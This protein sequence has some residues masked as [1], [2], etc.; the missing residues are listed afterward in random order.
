MT[1]LMAVG[2]IAISLGIGLI[3]IL[4]NWGGEVQAPGTVVEEGQVPGTI[5]YAE[6]D[7]DQ[8]IV[9]IEA[10]G[11]DQQDLVTRPA[12]RDDASGFA[13]SPDGQWIA[14]FD[15]NEEDESS[16]A[17]IVLTSAD[18]SESE[19]INMPPVLGTMHL[20]VGLGWSHDGS[21]LA[22]VHE[23]EATGQARIGIV[24]RESGELQVI[25]PD[26]T[27]QAVND[28]HPVWAPTQLALAF[29]R[30]EASGQ[31]SI[32]VLHQD[33]DEP[34]V[35]IQDDPRATQPGW[36]P[37]GDMIAYVGSGGESERHNVHLADLEADQIQNLSNHE[38]IDYLPTWSSRDQIAFMSDYGDTNYDIFVV[39]PAGNEL[40]NLTED[41]AWSA[42]HPDWSDD[43]RYLTFTSENPEQNRWRINVFDINQERLYT[44]HESENPL[45]HAQ[46]RPDG[47][48]EEEATAEPDPVGETTA[49]DTEI[50]D[51][52]LEAIRRSAEL[53]IEGDDSPV[54]LR[55]NGET[56]TQAQIQSNQSNV[57]FRRSAMQGM[58]D[59][60][61]IDHPP[62]QIYN[63]MFIELID[64]YGPENV[65][66]GTA[67][68]NASIQVYA[69]DNDLTA[70][71]DQVDV[72]MEQ[73]RETNELMEQ[74]TPQAG[75]A[76]GTALID[77]I[78]EGRYWDEYL[79]EVLANQI[80]EQNVNEAVWD[81]ADLDPEPGA[82]F[83]LER[84]HYLAE[85]R[86]DLV[87]E[88]DI[89]TVD[90]SAL[91][92]ADL[93]RAVE[94]ITEAYPDLQQQRIDW[95][96]DMSRSGDDD[97]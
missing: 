35:L 94:Y 45:F 97:E 9:R 71:D 64:A 15:S 14:W 55:V 11:T 74:Q 28:M 67:L 23:E 95:Q 84:G 48:P 31:R 25:E 61:E 1:G 52:Q 20:N 42:Y 38:R 44:V 88:A 13:W 77:V 16:A 49:N 26:S 81:A 91:T 58:L 63:E 46:W 21:S 72:A 47:E 60:P 65:G 39:D 87:Q 3:F 70:T 34:V 12:S 19:R 7:G 51:E 76:I 8:A 62:M 6:Y 93:E 30:A 92:D 18:G 57:E 5:L 80:T 86:A 43:G 10:D 36:S 17:T 32:Q 2:L 53:F 59:D 90:E 79:P 22:F 24:D 66:L 69:E 27:D 83:Q 73:Q 29:S 50:T 41:Y 78:G 4:G 37:D 89:E 82:T 40:R 56:I 68:M 75:A 54:A 85:F 33:G 96:R